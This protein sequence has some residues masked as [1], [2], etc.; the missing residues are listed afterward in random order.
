VRRLWS[1]AQRA[2]EGISAALFFAMF[3]L[4]LLGIAMRYLADAPLAW[5]DEL[6]MVLF[7]WL[8]FLTEAVVIDER[9]QISFDVIYDVV[10]ARGRRAIGLAAALALASL[11]LASLP[12]VIDYVRFL[13]RERTAV[14]QWRLDLVYACFVVFWAAVVARSLAKIGRLAGPRWRV[15]VAPPRPDERA[16]ILG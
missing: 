16:S 9:E 5:T 4:F 6:I 11:F 3:A 14:L 13:W 7:I 10:G 2:A 8:V 1:G 12:T 15:A